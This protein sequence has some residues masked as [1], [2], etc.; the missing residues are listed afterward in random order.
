ME[1]MNIYQL[2]NKLYTYFKL[3]TIFKNNRLYKHTYSYINESTDKMETEYYKN[4]KIYNSNLDIRSNPVKR[5][6][7]EYIS[8]FINHGTTKNIII[9]F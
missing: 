9:T 5:A 7:G 1:R 6:I 4:D 3:S 2:Q 8:D